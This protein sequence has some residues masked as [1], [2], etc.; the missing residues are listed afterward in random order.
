MV[1]AAAAAAADDVLEMDGDRV[2]VTAGEAAFV[3]VALLVEEERARAGKRVAEGV[4]GDLAG[5]EASRL[6]E[7]P[8]AAVSRRVGLSIAGEEGTL[9][10]PS[11]CSL[12]PPR[13]KRKGEAGSWAPLLR[14]SMEK[15]ESDTGVIMML[16]LL[17]PVRTHFV[18]ILLMPT[19]LML[20]LARGAFLE[21]RGGGPLNA[22]LS[23]V[24]SIFFV[25][26]LTSARAGNGDPL[27]ASPSRQ[28]SITI[29]HAWIGVN[30]TPLWRT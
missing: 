25:D 28:T 9:L 29:V 3:P 6:D 1:A 16:T 27:T 13:E 12:L 18:V 2:A 23:S 24:T 7:E 5:V 15:A 19:R 10:L 11:D 20:M 8:A 21:P 22:A 4:M 14:S 17:S 26:G 30:V